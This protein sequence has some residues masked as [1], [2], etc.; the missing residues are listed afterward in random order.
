MFF[1]RNRIVLFL[2]LFPIVA[3]GQQTSVVADEVTRLPILHANVYTGKGKAFRSAISDEQGRV[4]VTFPFNR[5][6]VS[7]LN[8]ERRTI[9]HLS[10]T[11]WL[12]PR[13]NSTPDVVVRSK[14]PEWIRPFLKRFVD[15][16]TTRY[17]AHDHPFAYHYF[18]QSIGERQYYTYESDG[19]LCLRSK[20]HNGY[21]FCQGRGII[22]AADST[23]LTDVQNLRR[24]LHEDFVDEMDRSFIREHRFYVNGDYE[25]RAGEVELLF[26][27]KK[28]TDDRGRFVVDTTRCLVLSATRT[29]GRKSNIHLRMPSFL[30]AMAKWLSGYGVDAWNVD[31]HVR[32]VESGGQYYPA[33]AAYKLFFKAHESSPD[34]REEE[35]SEQMGGGFTNMESTLTLTPTDSALPTAD[36]IVSTASFSTT[37][38]TSVVGKWLNLPRTW[39]IKY[40]SDAERAYEVRLAHLN[41]ELVI[42]E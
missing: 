20:A 8:Y 37:D 33:E 27:S 22:T 42:Q 38:T 36:D 10:D 11:I 35:F 23:E 30:L 12:K 4:T 7:H 25:G 26:R 18:S 14:E 28:N 9:S 6:T 19:L 34:K 31:Y 2:C 15:E 17:A 1:C 5:L 41:A 39:Y 13:Y 29:L 40:N 32:Y 24:L 3:L 21:A 16:K